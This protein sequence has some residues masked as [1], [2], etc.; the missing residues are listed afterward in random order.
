MIFLLVVVLATDASASPYDVGWATLG[1]ALGR[2]PV[3][4]GDLRDRS[5]RAPCGDGV[6]KLGGRFAAG[7]GLGRWGVELQVATFPFEDTSAMDWRDHER[8]A[9]LWGP[10]VRYAVLRSHGFDVSVRAGIQHGSFD[11]QSSST[12]TTCSDE[13]PGHCSSSTYDPPG[14]PVWAV[15]GGVTLQW[16]ARFDGGFFALQADLDATAISAT[17][18]DREVFGLATSRT[19]GFTFGSMWNLH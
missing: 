19:F 18:P 7:G 12:G 1:L 3:F 14:Y 15:S 13:V 2:T 10:I 9:F 6:C 11:G 8:T 4:H 5:E 16:R 17:Y